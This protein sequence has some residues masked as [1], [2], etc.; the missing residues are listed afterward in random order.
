MAG[1]CEER[2]AMSQQE[3]L[4]QLRRE[5]FERVSEYYRLR[6]M[7]GFVPGESRVNYAGAVF[8]EREV[9]SVIDSLLRGWFGLGPK[10]REFCD[11]FSEYL[12]VYRTLLVNSGSSAN[13]LA[14]TALMSPR[15]ERRVMPGDEVVTPAVTFPTTLNP[16]I[17]NS[18]NPVLVDVDVE[19]LNVDVELLNE[20]V[21]RKTRVLMLPHTLGNP[22]DMDAVMDIVEDYGLYLI[23][24]NCDALG[25]EFDGRK[26]GSFGVLSTC[27]FYPAHHIT[28]GEGGAVCVVDEDVR[29]YRVVRSLRDWGRDCWCESDETSPYGACG[30]RFEWEVDGMKY[31]HRYIYSHIGYNLKPTEMQAAIGV[32]QIKRIDEFNR[33]RRRNFRYMY[34]RLGKY[35]DYLILARWHRKADPAWFAFPITIGE[36]APFSR[37]ELVRFLED[38]RIQTR[39]IFAG[40]IR[41]QP[42]YRECRFRCVGS[43]EATEY[44]MRNSFFIGVYPGIDE[45]RLEYVTGVF[46]EF[47]E[48]AGR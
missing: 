19:T 17:Q 37:N 28:M 20:A 2:R 21:S 23:E 27:S 39:L 25:S 30:R 8:D 33:I 34:E 24:D 41:K 36:D 40:D 31:D 10:A 14:L 16:I 12:G 1:R 42:A 44:V 38:R 35:S 15:L 7:Q 32:E 45:R 46:E 18:L 5:I 22:N 43:M 9:I 29:L 11:R 4:E 26:T 3:R 47:F 48:G 6:G 13:L